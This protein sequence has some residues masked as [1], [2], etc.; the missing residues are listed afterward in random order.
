MICRQC[1]RCG[2]RR[3]Y[4]TV[5]KPWKCE[6][7]GA[8]MDDRHEKPLEKRIKEIIDGRENDV[9]NELL[10]QQSRVP[11]LAENP[12]SKR[13]KPGRVP[14]KKKKRHEEGAEKII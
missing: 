3:W 4:S 1:P 6:E 10:R 13:G 2:T 14:G 9:G 12:D 5:T 8:R 7:C 11:N